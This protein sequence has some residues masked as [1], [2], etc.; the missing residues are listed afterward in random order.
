MPCPLRDK[1]FLYEVGGELVRED[2]DESRNYLQCKI[3][4]ACYDEKDVKECTRI[5]YKFIHLGER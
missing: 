2:C 4:K 5:I 1:C 3:Y